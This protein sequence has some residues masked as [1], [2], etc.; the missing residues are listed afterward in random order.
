MTT[1]ERLLLSGCAAGLQIAEVCHRKLEA[2][3]LPRYPSRTGSS[4]CAWFTTHL[5]IGVIW[6]KGNIGDLEPLDV[7]LLTDFGNRQTH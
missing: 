2:S 1:Q 4:G 7:K 5:R 6:G 3:L